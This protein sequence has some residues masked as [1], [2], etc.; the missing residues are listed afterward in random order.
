M[1]KI[2]TPPPLNLLIADL[3]LDINEEST[4]FLINLILD[5][6]NDLAN[7]KDIEK[8]DLEDLV[9]KIPIMEYPEMTDKLRRMTMEDFFLPITNSLS[10]LS[11]SI[12]TANICRM[13][14]EVIALT[15]KSMM[16]KKL[17]KNEK[18]KDG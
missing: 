18:V 15:N 17:E 5:L 6:A 1:W 10:D 2:P 4:L 8:S 14:L 7:G 9:I 13:E 12:I 16:V 11:S 3:G